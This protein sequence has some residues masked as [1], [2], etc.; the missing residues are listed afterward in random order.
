M[1]VSADGALSVFIR[2]RS[3][4]RLRS[5]TEPELLN[6]YRRHV[7]YKSQEMRGDAIP[8]SSVRVWTDEHQ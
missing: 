6:A 5:E 4:S 1:R 2:V 3:M 7:Y 8:R